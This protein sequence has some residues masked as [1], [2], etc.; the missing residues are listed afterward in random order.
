MHIIN[1]VTNLVQVQWTVDD[2]V[3]PYMDTYVFTEDEY[4]ALT[5]EALEA[6]QTQ[7]YQDWL[8]YISNPTGN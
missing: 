1:T 2:A 4:N 3:Y 8:D 6:K 5:P 7:Q